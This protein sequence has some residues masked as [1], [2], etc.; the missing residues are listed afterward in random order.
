MPTRSVTTGRGGPRA[1]RAT[2]KLPHEQDE[3]VG[4]TGG[5]AS[6]PMQQAHQDLARGLQETDRGP[7]AD[8]I[9]SRL[10]R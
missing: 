2:P 4:M 7:Q 1:R 8:R 3:S 6:K 9:Y 10:K 5:V